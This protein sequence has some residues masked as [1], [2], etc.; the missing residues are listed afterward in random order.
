[1]II[2]VLIVIVIAFIFILKSSKK[3]KINKDLNTIAI[4]GAPGMGKTY[5]GTKLALKRLAVN[6]EKTR[7]FNKRFAWNIF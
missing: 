2:I 6:R 7:K 1:M 3:D 5:I 4:M